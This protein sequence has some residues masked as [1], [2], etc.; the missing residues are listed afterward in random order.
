MLGYIE[1]VHMGETKAF[2]GERKRGGKKN[3][4]HDS[5]LQS[6]SQKA[7]RKMKEEKTFLIS[8]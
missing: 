2:T 3:T 5:I 4:P 1:S 7:V 6:Y 8:V